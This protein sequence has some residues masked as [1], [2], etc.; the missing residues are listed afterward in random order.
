MKRKT[1]EELQ[2]RVITGTASEQKKVDFL[3]AWG[4]QGDEGPRSLLEDLAADNSWEVR[5][6]AL[7]TMVLDLFQH[8]SHGRLIG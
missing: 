7:Q 3:C 1:F 2:R 4:R 6:Y 8:L 5:Y